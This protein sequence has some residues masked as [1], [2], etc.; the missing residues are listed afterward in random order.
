MAENDGICADFVRILGTDRRT[1]VRTD[2]LTFLTLTQVEPENIYAFF[3]QDIN[4]A[5]SQNPK[6]NSDVPRVDS[7]R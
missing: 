7:A 6:V 5:V 1:Y 4:T 2:V 3:L